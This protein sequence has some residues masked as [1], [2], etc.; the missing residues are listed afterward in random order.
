[1]GKSWVFFIKQL[2]QKDIGDLFYQIR[3]QSVKKAVASMKN[4]KIMRIKVQKDVLLH[5]T[6]QKSKKML[7]TP[8]EFRQQLSQKH[9]NRHL[10]SK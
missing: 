9:S 5:L 8:K 2:E 10:I 1:M 3:A 4:H 6:C 7:E